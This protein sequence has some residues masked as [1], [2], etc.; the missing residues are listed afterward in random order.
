MT[1]D[2]SINLSSFAAEQFISIYNSF[3]TGDHKDNAKSYCKYLSRALS[4]IIEGRSAHSFCYSR[5]IN[6]PKGEKIVNPP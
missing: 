1:A 6:P 5:D 3:Y 2:I 4:L